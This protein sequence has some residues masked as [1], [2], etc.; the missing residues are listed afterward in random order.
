MDWLKTQFELLLIQDPSS[1]L[2]VSLGWPA[3][4][5]SMLLS[6]SGIYFQKPRLLLVAAVLILPISLYFFGANN[7][8]GKVFPLFPILIVVCWYTL[9]N[10]LLFI[11][12]SI[13]IL[14]LSMFSYLA[15]MVANQ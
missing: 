2:I 6:I 13:L 14:P 5:L 1:L 10:K 8:I 11:T 3:V 4:I 12:W 7:W 15:F 9:R